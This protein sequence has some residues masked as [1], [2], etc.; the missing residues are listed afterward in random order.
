MPSNKNVTGGWQWTTAPGGYDKHVKDLHERYVRE[1]GAPYQSFVKRSK[2]EQKELDN[3]RKEVSLVRKGQQFRNI[4]VTPN[5]SPIGLNA[6]EMILLR[7]NKA[8]ARRFLAEVTGNRNILETDIEAFYKNMDEN[9]P[10][11]IQKYRKENKIKSNKEVVNFAKNNFIRQEIGKKNTATQYELPPKDVATQWEEIPQNDQ[12][13]KT[14]EN[15]VKQIKKS[16]EIEAGDKNIFKPTE[17]LKEEP[18]IR[19]A[20]LNKKPEIETN[21]IPNLNQEFDKNEYLNSLPPKKLEQLNALK[22]EISKYKALNKGG[23]WNGSIDP[24]IELATNSRGLEIILDGLKSDFE[25][26]VQNPELRQSLLNQSLEKPQIENVVE[27]EGQ[28][29]KRLQEAAKKAIEFGTQ[30][31]DMPL[32]NEEEIFNLEK[33]E[34]SREQLLE[35]ELK[36][37]EEAL[38]Y[39]RNLRLEQEENIKNYTS[40]I[41]QAGIF[42]DESEGNKTNRSNISRKSLDNNDLLK[43]T[44]KKHPDQ[45]ENIIKHTDQQEELALD[46]LALQ[47]ANIKKQAN[48]IIDQANKQK[49]DISKRLADRKLNKSF[50]TDRSNLSAKKVSEIQNANQFEDYPI[51]PRLPLRNIDAKAI[52]K[53]RN[54]LLGIIQA[55]E[56]NILSSTL[57]LE[58]YPDSD[59]AKNVEKYKKKLEEFKAKLAKLDQLNQ[60]ANK[61]PEQNVG[62]ANQSKNFTDLDP[63]KLQLKN[64]LK[65]AK[66]E[67][68]IVEEAFKADPT[69]QELSAK[70]DLANKEIKNLEAQ[71]NSDK[72]LGGMPPKK[73]IEEQSNYSGE[74][75]QRPLRLKPGQKPEIAVAEHNLARLTKEREKRSAVA[76]ELQTKIAQLEKLDPDTTPAMYQAILSNPFYSDSNP[77]YKF[78]VNTGR[79]STGKNMVELKILAS[80][81]KTAFDMLKRG[82]DVDDPLALKTKGV[83]P[84]FQNKS[85][86]TLGIAAN[87]YSMAYHALKP[88][89]EL[90]KKLA[91]ENK[92]IAEL[93][94]DIDLNEGKVLLSK[95]LEPITE[96]RLEKS[97][98]SRNSNFTKK[99]NFS[100]KSDKSFFQNKLVN[101]GQRQQDLVEIARRELEAEKEKFLPKPE[102]LVELPVRTEPTAREFIQTEQEQ[103]PN[104]ENVPQNEQQVQLNRIKNAQ[105]A[106]QTQQENLDSQPLQQNPQTQF[107]IEDYD[108][109]EDPSNILKQFEPVVKNNLARKSLSNIN[110]NEEINSKGNFNYDDQDFL[111][112][113]SQIDDSDYVDSLEGEENADVIRFARNKLKF[114]I[115]DL[116]ELQQE[117]DNLNEINTLKLGQLN[118]EIN[119]LKSNN[120]DPQKIQQLES[121]RKPIAQQIRAYNEHIKNRNNQGEGSPLPPDLETHLMK[122]KRIRE[123]EEDK[124]RIAP[125]NEMHEQART[126]AKKSL[127]NPLLDIAAK[128]A[129]QNL[130][131]PKL[132]IQDRTNE[133]LNRI[134]ES[135]EE[136]IDKHIATRTKR[137]IDVLKD[138]ARESFL[139]DELPAVNNQ[140]VMN[141]GFYSGAR[142]AAIERA[143]RDRDRHIKREIARML[144]HGEEQALAQYNTQNNLWSN[145]GQVAGQAAGRQSEI[146]NSNIGNLEK[147]EEAKKKAVKQDALMIG[148]MANENQQQEQNQINAALHEWNE[149]TQHNT[150][151]L[152][153]EAA[154]LQGVVPVGRQIQTSEELGQPKAPNAMNS[155]GGMMDLVGSMFKKGGS[156][157]GSSNKSKLVSMVHPKTQEK[158][159]IPYHIVKTALKDGL[160]Y[161]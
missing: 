140:F 75:L 12:I 74:S 125:M 130:N 87:K 155:M 67:A 44:I 145:L 119:N 106:I 94:D 49:E 28:R 15:L 22:A 80:K 149:Q 131:N 43:K 84:D 142:E 154:M 151:Q 23:K 77:D 73:S 32:T 126:I 121:L 24:E 69:N 95:Q 160:I 30:T 48:F 72:L 99:S 108:I 133:Y 82:E 54:N 37:A 91:D 1:L 161:G 114:D 129:E 60:S 5:S 20:D 157:K 146:E 70:Y 13:K 88:V 107:N 59:E 2:E 57:H 103:R 85:S 56:N 122:L 42:D 101:E 17:Q 65:L 33:S 41:K 86:L 16:E 25:Q 27:T 109:S 132:N 19:K 26:K 159:D 158:Y 134:K 68:S 92:V 150:R 6:D 14:A 52:E 66:A 105:Q 116:H 123:L 35:K 50:K 51:I 138:E 112:N 7:T 40:Q 120:A 45:A 53:K 31:E 76:N 143:K 156:V 124:K 39:E 102:N 3:L 111:D 34:I 9:Y 137:L 71:L 81:Y 104:I 113:Q 46:N 61:A 38:N 127:G 10:N 144:S 55:Y 47:E 152:E 58:K 79:I 96:A 90:K 128:R 78:D 139:E 89:I 64:K 63:I 117:E 110:E 11:I 98:A 21:V 136:Y 153:K 8:F 118:E 83:L 148:Q 62:N 115:E 100:K 29:N 36:A 135:P 147:L 93:N 18:F 141:G 97:N 4:S